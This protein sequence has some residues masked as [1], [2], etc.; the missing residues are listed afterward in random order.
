MQVCIFICIWSKAYYLT[1][2]NDSTLAFK[3][4]YFEDFFTIF[5]LIN[6]GAEESAPFFEKNQQRLYYAKNRSFISMFPLPE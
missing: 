5:Q 3:S 4:Q 1:P 2:Y 6:K